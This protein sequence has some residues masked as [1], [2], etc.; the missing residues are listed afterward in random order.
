MVGERTQKKYRLGDEVQILLVRANVEE[1]NLDFVLKDNGAYDPA[2]MKTPCA[3]A[4][5]RA[6]PGIKKREAKSAAKAGRRAGKAAGSRRSGIL[7]PSRWRM[8]VRRKRKSTAAGGTASAALREKSFPI[9]NRKRK[10]SG[11][12]RQE[13]TGARPERTSAGAVQRAAAAVPVRIITA[14]A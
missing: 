11:V 13:K 12:K 3:A 8:P 6:L 10:A 2:A 9:R 4:A 14:S 1:R 5:K 7:S